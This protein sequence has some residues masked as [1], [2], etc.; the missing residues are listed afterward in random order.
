MAAKISKQEF[1]VFAWIFLPM[2]ALIPIAF[3][4]ESHCMFEKRERFPYPYHITYPGGMVTFYSRLDWEEEKKLAKGRMILC[5]RDQEIIDSAKYY[6]DNYNFFIFAPERVKPKDKLE[7]V[8]TRR[9]DYSTRKYSTRGATRYYRTQ[10]RTSYPEERCKIRI[11][12]KEDYF[13]RWRIKRDLKRL[14]KKIERVKK[15]IIELQEEISTKKR[16]QRRSYLTHKKV[17]PLAKKYYL[18]VEKLALLGNVEHLYDGLKNPFI[19]NYKGEIRNGLLHLKLLLAKEEPQKAI[20]LVESQATWN[21]P[22][23]IRN[24]DSS[25]FHQKYRTGSLDQKYD[26][27]MQSNWTYYNYAQEMGALS[28]ELQGEIYSQALDSI[29]SG[30]I[31]MLSKIP[32]ELDKTENPFAKQAAAYALEVLDKDGPLYPNLT[33]DQLE[34]FP[35]YSNARVTE[36]INGQFKNIDCYSNYERWKEKCESIVNSRNT[37]N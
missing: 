37:K 5:L 11:I 30:S 3:L 6:D 29:T 18:Y 33:T 36:Y 28:L 2:I 15:E 26:L 9:H 8:I 14:P 24:I 35:C 13:N 4:I 17:E 25:Y 19:T 16:E 21:S 31:W 1:R 23:L 7:L 20:E 22:I 12:S 27:I 32:L 34:Q 10:S